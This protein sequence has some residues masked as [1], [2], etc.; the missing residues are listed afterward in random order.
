MSTEAAAL[1]WTDGRAT[2]NGIELAW[3]SA[4]PLDAEPVLL[5][6]GLA[7]QLIHW[8]EG[9]CAELVARGFR[10]IRFDNRDIGLSASGDRGLRPRLTRDSVL[11]R[12]GLQAGPA[13]YTL[14]DMAQDTASLSQVLGLGKVHLVGVSMGG[15]I[16]QLVAARFP[17]RVASL[18]SI[19]SGTNDPRL[20]LP[21]LDVLLQ[22]FTPRRRGQ[23]RAQAVERYLRMFRKI[24]S[25]AYPL[26]E[27]ELRD[28]ALRALER[29]DRI[30]GIVRQLHA[31]VVTGSIE[32]WLPQVTAPT[33]IIHGLADPLIRPAGGRRSARCISGSRLELIPGMGHDLPA[34]LWPRLAQI[35]ASNAQQAHL[36]RA[37]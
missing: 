33:V 16:A 19:M 9:F 2:A 25:P 17:E 7:A 30:D 8:P 24:A 20:P 15:M 10:V 31:I 34:A 12:A 21:R 37:A 14:H 22:L 4:G 28:I 3:E 36:V 13:N 5:V 11:T 1:N 26:R 6:M 32:R 27:P 35:I 23:S 29:D 18:A